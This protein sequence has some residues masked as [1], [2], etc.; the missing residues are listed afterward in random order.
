MNLNLNNATYFATPWP[1]VVIE[2]FI[3]DASIVDQLA[4]NSELATAITSHSLLPGQRAEVGA[5]DIVKNNLPSS[6]A[7]V[8]NLIDSSPELAE[9]LHNQ[10]AAALTAE[11]TTMSAD[12]FKT[13]T[14]R[15]STYGCYNYTPSQTP[16]KG[17]HLD[18]GK[19]IYSGM[20]YFREDSDTTAGSELLLWDESQSLEKVI[21]YKKNLAIFWPN[22]TNTWHSVSDRMPSADN[23]R[24]YINVLIEGDTKLHDYKTD[25]DSNGDHDYHFKVVNRYV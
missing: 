17:L 15:K 3:D 25:K 24:R 2:D 14:K 21:P 8:L 4:N 5:A 13:F 7:D 16:L 22:L 11:Y 1:H 23:L 10:F 18:N 20:I 6:I 19:K 9:L 12:N